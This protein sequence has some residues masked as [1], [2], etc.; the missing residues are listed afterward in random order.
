MSTGQLTTAVELLERSLAY[1]RGTLVE[2]RPH[3]LDRAT[4]C[5]R[6]DLGDLLR[7]MS[8]ALDT[9]LEASQGYV[10]V[11]EMPWTPLPPLPWSTGPVEALQVK[12]CTLLGAWSRPTPARLVVGEQP[13]PP[14][15]V[16]AAA[17][18][19]ITVHGWDVGQAVAGPDGAR[20]PPALAVAL[21]PVASALVTP[22]D[23]PD[24]F[25]AARP[26]AADA[27]VDVRLLARVGRTQPST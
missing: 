2:V 27:A 14:A 25:A 17:A 19:E 23:R 26:V 10:V 8:D 13:V 15:V 3:H 5:A 24:R 20:V 21:L 4:P 9:F 18:L 6:W 7:H 11:D 22:E 1:T 16:V 12:A